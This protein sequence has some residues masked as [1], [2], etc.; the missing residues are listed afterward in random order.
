MKSTF[1]IVIF[2]VLAL[3]LCMAAFAAESTVYLDGVGTDANCYA[4]LEDAVEAVADGGTV[5]LTADYATANKALH[6]PTKSFTLTAENGAVLTLGRT[7]VI[8]G[9]VVFDNITIKNGA[10]STVD[11][12]YCSGYSLTVTS[13]V[14]TVAK[15]GR[16]TT[17]FA[18][19]SDV[20]K[21]PMLRQRAKL[22]FT[23]AIG[24]L[25]TVQ[26]IRERLPT[27]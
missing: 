8:Y 21:Y 20:S 10:A 1:R 4:K 24:T 9:D 17:I 16:Y 14:T 22:N 27:P 12:I 2:L 6:L 15:S 19:T 25:C 18:G 23:A 26:T 5:V 13:S 11:F 3:C 7:F